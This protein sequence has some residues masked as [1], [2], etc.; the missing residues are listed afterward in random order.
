MNAWYN[1]TYQGNVSHIDVFGDI[2]S[3]NLTAEAFIAEIGR[4]ADKELVLNI[5]SLGGAVNDALQIHDFLT[6]YPKKVTAKI[7]GL[8][9]SSATIIAMAADEV[10]MSENALFLVHNVWTPQTS[11][12]AADLEKE[13]ESL[14][15][16]DELLINIYKKKTK[17]RSN[18]IS[19]LMA[20]EKWL[21]AEEALR[22]GFIDKIYIPSKDI[23]NSVVLNKIAENKL[24]TLPVNYNNDVIDEVFT[25]YKAAVNMSFSE[26]ERWA[27]NECS[28]EASVD[29]KPINR[30][31]RLLSKNK[32]EWTLNDVEEANK[33]IAFIARMIEVEEGEQVSEDCPYS[34]KYISLK[35]W[36]YDM[37][38]TRAEQ[39]GEDEYTTMQEAEER[40]VELGCSG[41]HTHDSGY[42]TIYMP[43]E[44]HS[45]YLETKNLFK[46][47]LEKINEKVDLIINKI[48]GLFNAEGKEVEVLNKTEVEATLNAEIDELKN[49]YEFQIETFQDSLKS[50][51]ENLELKNQ[52][53]SE[54]KN[55]FEESLKELTE[56]I[57]KLE[58]NETK[59]V[60]SED[61]P[62][63]SVEVEKT[64]FDFLAD[65]LKSI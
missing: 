13:A 29:R 24:P 57:D 23:I 27:A 48:E 43:C 18:T 60:K 15:Q 9:A 35:N 14:R 53:I 6:S 45:I 61:A 36:A 31:L 3:W 16:I 7:T 39:V 64:A 32:A 26:L 42:T 50:A 12:N 17:R 34:K 51:E 10:L 49:L 25:K 37:R 28:R 30:N 65:R 47:S 58:A 20:E 38:K 56:K 41:S 54:L 63:E 19:N 22:L 4:E 62:L 44:S 1:L 40:A 11:G 21:D 52:E 8:T 55:G 33:T 2:G 5:S 59:A 46:M